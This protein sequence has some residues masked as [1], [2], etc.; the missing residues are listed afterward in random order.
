MESANE[1]VLYGGMIIVMEVPALQPLNMAMTR[2]K[3]QQRNILSALSS[4]IPQGVVQHLF[5]RLLCSSA[6]LPEVKL[7]EQ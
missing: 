3:R 6:F 5:D 7:R 2:D 1:P 4:M